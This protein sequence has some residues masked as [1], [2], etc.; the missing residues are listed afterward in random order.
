MKTRN[1][2]TIGWERR[3]PVCLNIRGHVASKQDA[4][5]PSLWKMKTRHSQITQITQSGKVEEAPGGCKEYK[6]TFL[7]LSPNLCNLRNL[8]IE[9]QGLMLGAQTSCLP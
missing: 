8:R 7:R 4:C 2:H 5:A 6:R 3:H 9:F 1:T